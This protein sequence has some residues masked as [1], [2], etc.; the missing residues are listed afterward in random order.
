VKELPLLEEPESARAV[1]AVVA[2]ARKVLSL[3]HTAI[4]ATVTA[5]GTA[6]KQPG[7]SAKAA[8][9]AVSSRDGKPALNRGTSSLPGRGVMAGSSKKSK[10]KAGPRYGEKAPAAMVQAEEEASVLASSPPMLAELVSGIN[11]GAH[12]TVAA[13]KAAS[14]SRLSAPPAWMAAMAAADVLMALR[15]TLALLSRLLDNA[16]K[17]YYW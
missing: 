13:G 1:A 17:A 12:A 11:S 15:P 5:N 4:S 14:M 2:S 8:A 6:A 16:Q 10:A 9:A 7:I 3:W